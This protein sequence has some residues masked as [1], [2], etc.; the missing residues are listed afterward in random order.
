MTVSEASR[1]D[2][3]ARALTI[4]ANASFVPIGIVTVLL[5]PLLPTL[6]QRWSLSYEQA[7][8]LFTAQFAASTIG[9]ALS[10]W[11]VS[12]YSFR[13]AINFGLLVM[14]IAVAFLP[15]TSY[16]S[17]LICIGAYG[18]GLGFSVPAGNLL[19]SEVNPHRRSSALNIV[20]FSWSAGA[21][22]CP[23]LMAAA[24]KARAINQLLF[25]VAGLLLAVIVGIMLLPSWVKE[26][27]SH[28][29]TGEKKKIDWRGRAFLLIAA[30][31]FLYVGVENAVG[32]WIASYAKSTGRMPLSL[33]VMTPSFFYFALLCGR[34]IAPLILRRVDE[35]KWARIEILIAC[36]GILGLILSHFTLAILASAIIAGAGLAPVY[37]ITIS[38]LS[39]EFGRSGARAGSVMF[40]MANLGGS[41][42]PWLVGFASSRSGSLRIG[43]SVPLIAAAIIF[44]VYLTKWT[45]MRTTDLE[46]G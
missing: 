34:W 26:P 6:S 42:I 32:G 27:Q 28:A 38:L 35:I 9:V 17:G 4:A 12:R 3:S 31:F 20:N 14:A 30:L 2:S 10:G 36:A 21:V 43:L 7:G 16:H 11:M 1:A 18:A 13:F 23:F 22:A 33:A 39:R 41:S 25:A 44:V 40:T 24:F 46:Q 15:L 45:P 37:P 5:G 29:S 8:T 19:V